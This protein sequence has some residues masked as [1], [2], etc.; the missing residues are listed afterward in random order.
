[1]LAKTE[2][3]LWAMGREMMMR[4][5]FSFLFRLYLQFGLV[6][7]HNISP[8]L[9]NYHSF[10]FSFFKACVI[11]IFFSFSH[12]YFFSFLLFLLVGRT[13][14]DA[15]YVYLFVKL[16][17]VLYVYLSF[18]ANLRF[19]FIKSQ[20]KSIKSSHLICQYQT[21]NCARTLD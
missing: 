1:M 12:Y 9:I 21:I 20:H 13:P 5:A 18:L 4:F 11:I 19:F 6:A 14:F 7:H 3:L 8:F 15:L 2:V 16:L 10:Y 17:R